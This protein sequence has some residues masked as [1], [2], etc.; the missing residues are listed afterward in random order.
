MMSS[1]TCALSG[2]P[3]YTIRWFSSIDGMSGG[4]PIRAP[5]TICPLDAPAA[6]A[7]MR[8]P[9]RVTAV[10]GGGTA[11]GDQPSARSGST[12]SVMQP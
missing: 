7:P 9:P 3:R 12:C 5:S 10:A 4:G 6:L 11:I 8:R 1:V 2:N